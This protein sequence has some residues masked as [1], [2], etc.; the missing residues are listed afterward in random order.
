MEK[1]QRE[2]TYK[3]GG[4]IFVPK[5]RLGHYHKRILKMD[6]NIGLYHVFSCLRKDKHNFSK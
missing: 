4:S 2:L 3:D 1:K 6:R 5:L